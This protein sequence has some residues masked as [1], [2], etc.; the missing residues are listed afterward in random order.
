VGY[1]DVFKCELH[2]KM[3]APKLFNSSNTTEVKAVKNEAKLL[4]SLRHPN[5]VQFV[6]YAVNK[7]EHYII[8][9]LMSKDLRMYLK[10][11]VTASSCRYN[12]TDSGGNEIL[13]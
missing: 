4:A 7:N 8:A 2:G 12:A 13:A 11:N 10:E 6:G 9:E 3:A 5:V 1:A